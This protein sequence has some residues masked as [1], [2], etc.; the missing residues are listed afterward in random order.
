[1]KELKS[2]DWLIDWLIDL[3]FYQQYFG[4]LFMYESICMVII[5]DVKSNTCAIFLMQWY[6]IF[7]Y[8]WYCDILISSSWYKVWILWYLISWYQVS[9][10]WYLDIWYVVLWYLVLWYMPLNIWYHDVRY[11]Y[12]W[13]FISGVMISGIMIWYLDI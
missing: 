10:L 2:D 6:V 1:M 3:A 12:T 9:I 13:I 7:L 4:H 5:R 8:I 11:H